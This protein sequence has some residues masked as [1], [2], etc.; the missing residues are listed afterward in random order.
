[1]QGLLPIIKEWYYD[2]NRVPFLVVVIDLILNAFLLV[3]I[4]FNS[5][6][7]TEGSYLTHLYNIF[8]SCYRSHHQDISGGS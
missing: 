1:M 7:I 2:I 3:V 5:Q 4:I 8:R 6:D